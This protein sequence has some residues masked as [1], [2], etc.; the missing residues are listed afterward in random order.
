[1][2]AVLSTLVRP[3]QR[4]IAK[5]TNKTNVFNALVSL[6]SR[7]QSGIVSDSNKSH[8]MIESRRYLELKNPDSNRY[9][10]HISTPEPNAHPLKEDYQAVE[11]PVINR[12]QDTL[13]DSALNKVVALG[14]NKISDHQDKI[15]LVAKALETLSADTEESLEEALLNLEKDLLEPLAEIGSDPG[16]IQSVTSLLFA[17]YKQLGQYNMTFQDLH[18]LVST[19]HTLRERDDDALDTYS[20]AKKAFWPGN[21]GYD[22]DMEYYLFEETLTRCK[23]ICEAEKT[24]GE[25][26]KIT[27]LR[28]LLSTFRGTEVSSNPLENFDW[29]RTKPL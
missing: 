26:K 21:L 11:I 19:L 27:D 8:T 24:P 14:L 29:S 13:F 18:D 4:Q 25:L 5:P 15:T 7:H 12:M 2:K 22:Q 10:L 17:V 20:D 3:L 28:G 6:Q 23:D 1:M 16:D 9:G